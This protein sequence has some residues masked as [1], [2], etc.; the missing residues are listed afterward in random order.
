MK[1]DKIEIGRRIKTALSGAHINQKQLADQLGIKSPSVTAYVQGT[2]NLPAEAYAIISKLCGVSIDWLIT[3]EQLPASETATKHITNI[4]TGYQVASVYSMAGAG[5]PHTLTEY[6]PVTSLLVPDRYMKPGI[7]PVLV[8]GRSMEQTIYDGAIVGVD[9]NDKFVIS[10]EIYG[11]WLPYEGA[12][13]RRIYMNFDHVTLHPD[14]TQFKSQEIPI[15]QIDA[16][17]FLIGRIKW[18]VQEY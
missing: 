2:S 11:I 8:R 12:I 9:S 18:V 7:I 17:N 5:D 15:K 1:V 10:G 14:N 6:E 13:I 16:D 4:E 3:G